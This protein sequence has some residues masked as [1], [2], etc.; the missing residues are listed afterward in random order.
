MSA[1]V[2]R[3]KEPPQRAYFL[4]HWCLARSSTDRYVRAMGTDAS[5][6]I[7]AGIIVVGKLPRLTTRW[8]EPPQVAFVQSKNEGAG[9][10]IRLARRVRLRTPRARRGT[11]RTRSARRALAKASSGAREPAGL[12][13]APRNGSW[14]AP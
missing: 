12:A 3:E 7:R 4:G 8:A 9:R 14:G 5:A 13:A 10:G 2:R 11:L 6:R 1:A